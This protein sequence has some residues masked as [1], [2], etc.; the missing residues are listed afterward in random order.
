MLF[1]QHGND[2]PRCLGKARRDKPTKML[3]TCSRWWLVECE[4]AA[5][6]R[7]IIAAHA[8]LH[9]PI[10]HT[11]YGKLPLYQNGVLVGRILDSGTNQVAP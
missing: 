4:S 8:D 5:A 7:R 1:V 9:E 6:G 3:P 2:T 10:D 11:L